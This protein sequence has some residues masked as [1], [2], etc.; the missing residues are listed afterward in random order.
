MITSI[1]VLLVITIIL[2]AVTL[3]FINRL[4]KIK[5]LLQVVYA[6]FIA[7]LGILLVLSIM[8]PI[9]FNK[10]RKKR[11]DAVIE[12]MILVRTIQ[13]AYKNEKGEYAN[14]F[15]KLIKFVEQ[16]SFALKEYVVIKKWD[17]D[18]IK[19]K[20]KAAELGIL[21]EV[22][23]KKSVYDS[24]CKGKYNVDEIKYIPYTDNEKEFRL[25][26]GETQTLSKVKVKVYELYAPY[27]IIFDDLDEQLV[28]NYIDERK[29]I[30]DSEGLQVGSMIMA[31]NN[32]G[33]WE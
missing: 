23:V 5:F 13:A 6:V 29:K 9:N 25:D 16:D 30:T 3:F 4:P 19:S 15:D 27:E 11:E 7:G 33:N 14:N 32:E 21:K 31:T 26:A 20:K 18:S 12:R 1:L 2:S 8:K 28:I 24:L 17:Q 22:I 10:E